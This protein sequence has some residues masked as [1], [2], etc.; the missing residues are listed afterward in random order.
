MTNAFETA[1]ASSAGLEVVIAAEPAVIVVGLLDLAAV[2]AGVAADMVAVSAVLVAAPGAII[3]QV[4]VADN[5]VAAD[6]KP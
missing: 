2:V 3:E 1:V 6:M 4:F 5:A